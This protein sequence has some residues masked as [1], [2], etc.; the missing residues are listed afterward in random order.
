MVT[1]SMAIW[2]L[3]SKGT[4]REISFL[5]IDL[6][7]IFCMLITG[8][9]CSLFSKPLDV[10]KTANLTL[11]TLAKAH[12]VETGVQPEGHDSGLPGC[13]DTVCRS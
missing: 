7:A 11:W 3:V 10:G 4:E 2:Y 5:V 1:V 9:T 12:R 6:P 8:Y 13:H